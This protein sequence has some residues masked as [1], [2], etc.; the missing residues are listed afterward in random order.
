SASEAA[1]AVELDSAS[2][3][4]QH[5]LGV[6]LLWQGDTNAA[7]K[8]F[9][10]A[11]VSGI[12]PFINPEPRFIQLF[13]NRQFTELVA[14]LRLIQNTKGQSDAWVSVL[15]TALS[16]REPE[17]TEAALVALEAA[18]RN[19]QLDASLYFG[20]PL[21]LG[22]ADRAF[23][24]A[25]TILRGKDAAIVL[26]GFFL[27]EAAELRA[28][29]LFASLVQELGLMSY[30]LR[31]GPP[32]VCRPNNMQ[33]PFCEGIMTRTNQLS[34]GKDRTPAVSTNRLASSA[35]MSSGTTLSVA[36]SQLAGGRWPIGNQI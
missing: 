22:D 26:E 8:Q 3:V 12:A 19:K 27:P 28:H 7:G 35:D 6:S 31:Y 4:N 14:M 11:A 36:N 29:P 32:D 10:K 5:R 2:P 9:D 16:T 25:V 15:E 20:V 17:D 30:W 33:P 1:L 21:F 34:R 18:W 23:A 13:R 24:A